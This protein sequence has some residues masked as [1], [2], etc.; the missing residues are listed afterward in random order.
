[1]KATLRE[2]ECKE[3]NLIPTFDLS[4]EHCEEEQLSQGYSERGE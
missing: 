1:M 2:F 4:C 3:V